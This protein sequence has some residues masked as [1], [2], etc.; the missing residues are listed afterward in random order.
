VA[1]FYEHLERFF[2]NVEAFGIM[3]IQQS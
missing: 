1:Y 2:Y 3:V